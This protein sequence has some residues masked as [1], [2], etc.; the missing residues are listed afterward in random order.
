M[1]TLPGTPSP[2]PGPALPPL[3]HSQWVSLALGLGRV[4]GRRISFLA[5]PVSLAGA[6]INFPALVFR[7]NPPLNTKTGMDLKDSLLFREGHFLWGAPTQKLPASFPG[8]ALV[9]LVKK[10]K[11]NKTEFQA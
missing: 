4:S 3:W 1:E 7:I 11:Q 8:E 5:S 2:G 9:F 10:Q 6:E